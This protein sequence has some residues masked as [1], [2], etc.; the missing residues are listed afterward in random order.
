MIPKKD[1]IMNGMKDSMKENIKDR[2]KDG[3]SMKKEMLEKI[4]GELGVKGKELCEKFEV[5]KEQMCDM[6]KKA[7]VKLDEIKDK[8]CE[9][10]KELVE[11]TM[12]MKVW[13][14]DRREKVCQCITEEKQKIVEEIKFIKGVIE[15]QLQIH[16]ENVKNCFKPE[17]TP[18][19][20]PE[21]PQED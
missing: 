18:E 1:D 12:A 20:K 3:M 15:E 11:R 19:E 6:K 4:L 2:F 7:V 5:A 16:H 17:E 14:L 21:E 8:I 13:A 10:K 9:M